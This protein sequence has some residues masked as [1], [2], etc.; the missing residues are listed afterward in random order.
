VR[1]C[2][3]QLA[4]PQLPVPLRSWTCPSV[5]ADFLRGFLSLTGSPPGHGLP[6]CR[7]A[8]TQSCS[9]PMPPRSCLGIPGPGTRRAIAGQ[10]L[11]TRCHATSACLGDRCQRTRRT[12]DAHRRRLPRLQVATYSQR[13]AINGNLVERRRVSIRKKNALCSILHVDRKLPSVFERVR[14]VTRVSRQAIR[15]AECHFLRACQAEG[16]QSTANGICT[17]NWMCRLAVHGRACPQNVVALTEPV[18]RAR[19]SATLNSR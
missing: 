13:I 7:R 18:G 2:E 15:G 9:A 8:V 19:L 5:M 1:R 3:G 12:S 10:A 4:M 14:R 11:R 17:A 16:S 6:A